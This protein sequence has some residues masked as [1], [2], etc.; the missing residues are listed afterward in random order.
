MFDFL[1]VQTISENAT[2]VTLIY[3]NLLA[4]TLSVIVAW[5]YEKTYRGLSYSRNYVQTLVLIAIVSSTVMQSVG[6][7]LA[8]GLGIM[9]AMAV[10]RFRTNFKDARDIVFMF[11]ALSIGVATGVHGFGIAVIGTLSFCLAAMVLYYSP[12]GSRSIFDG[13]LRFSLSIKE[14]DDS[15]YIENLLRQNC[16][17]FALITLKELNNGEILEYAYQIKLKNSISPDSF[18]S[19]F[20]DIKNISNITFL[21][22]EASVEL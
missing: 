1:T 18:V 6:D 5:V 8:R 19:N 14:H 11:A 16:K 17:N 7:S 13:M 22:Q 2:I 15:K 4:F 20:K 12:F 10:I 9:A 3:I 21:L